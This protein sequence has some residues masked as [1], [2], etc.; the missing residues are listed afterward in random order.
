MSPPTVSVNNLPPPSTEG[1]IIHT[2]DPARQK[3]RSGYAIGH[4]LDN[5]LTVLVSDEVPANLKSDWNTQAQFQ[6]NQAEYFKKTYNSYSSLMD[7]TGVGDAVATI[8]RDNN[9]YITH[10]IKYTSG[11]NKSQPMPGYYHVAKHLLLNNLLDM[12][13][14]KQ[15]TILSE[16]N[17]KLIEEMNYAS[18]VEN[19]FGTLSLESK[20]FD[21]ILNCLMTMAWI[22]KEERYIYRQSFRHTETSRSHELF[23][24]EMKTYAKRA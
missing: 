9:L 13:E 4:A 18:I 19:R 12:L 7:V 23:L 20:F 1:H 8:F 6:I 17:Q 10:Q 24:D 16:T 11:S 3:D 2:M 21:D 22:A 15:I 14:A 5:H